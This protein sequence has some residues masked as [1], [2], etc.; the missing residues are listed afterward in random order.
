MHTTRLLSPFFLALILTFLAHADDPAK[1]VKKAVE[2]STL[3]Q[4]GTKPFHLKA[5][6]SPSRNP[7]ETPDR[8]GE[9]EI[10]WESPTKWRREVRSPVF[11]Q[12][13]VVNGDREW[14]KN[15]GDYFPEWLREVSTALIDPVPALDDVLK[16]LAG[17][18]MKRLAGSTYYQWM[19]FSSNGTV[20]KSTGAGISITDST[21]LLFYGNG[22]AWGG[23]YHDY[24]DFHG[25]MVARTVSS[26]S[27]EVTAKIVTLEVLGPTPPEFFDTTAPG[28][29]AQLLQ[30]VVVDELDLR[31]NLLKQREVKWPPLTNGPL[32]GVLTAQV[33]IDRLG[34]VRQVGTVVSD[35]PAIEDAAQ[36]AIAEMQFKPY[37]VNGVAV[38]VVSKI[39][40]PF[41]TVR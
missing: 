31:K 9:A 29:D 17:A 36:Q 7:N 5:T 27:P 1:A 22:Q 26:G 8:N 41:K 25:R 23:L 33:S 37:M 19:E 3:N 35:N 30:T 39:T 13:A 34:R 10:W 40:M 12:V 38:Q 6:I 20:R 2:R 11:H 4:T 14:Q 28:G 16:N 32:E 15:E 18:D 21:G 24:K